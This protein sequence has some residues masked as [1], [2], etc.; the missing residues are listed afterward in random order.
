MHH[1]AADKLLEFAT[2]GCKTRTGKLWTREQMEEAICRG[3]H[4]SAMEEE[5]MEVLVK[6]VTAKV[7]HNQC[8]VVLWDDIKENPP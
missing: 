1:P 3:P 8:R 7:Q 2:K 6:E 4:I 5:A